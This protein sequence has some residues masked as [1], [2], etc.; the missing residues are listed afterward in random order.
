M[1]PTEVGALGATIRCIVTGRITQCGDAASGLRI[2]AWHDLQV[3]IPYGSEPCV[4]GPRSTR[5]VGEDVTDAVGGFSLTFDAPAEFEEACVFSSTVRIHVFDGA[6]RLWASAPRLVRTSVRIDHELVPGCTAASTGVRVINDSGIPVGGAQVFVNGELSGLTGATGHLVL[7]PALN[8]GDCLAAR[9]LVHENLVSRDEHD[10]D[11]NQN[12]NYRVY[13][14]SVRVRHDNDGDNIALEQHIVSN[15]SSV[16]VLRVR[17][18]NALV[19]LNLRVSIEWDASSTDS[20]RF[21]DRFS[22]MSELL[23]NATDGQFLV[24]RLAIADD[25]RFWDEADFRIYANQNQPSVATKDGMFGDTG[26]VRMNPNDANY[27]GTLLHELGHFGFGLGDEYEAADNWDPS[28]GPTRCT[29]RSTEPSGPYADGNEK[30]SCLM[31]GNRYRDQKKFCS[32]HPDA[33]HVDGTDQGPQDC[34]TDILNR[35][36]QTRWLLR[37]PRSRG[38]ILGRIPDSGVSLL[39]TSDPPSDINRPQSFIPLSGWKTI[40]RELR[41]NRAGLCEGLV[42]RIEQAGEPVIGA[43]IS[44]RTAAGRDLYLGATKSQY[45][46][47]YGVN[48]GP[49]ELPLRGVPVRDDI[50]VRVF[51][52]DVVMALI[53][54]ESCNS[55]LAIGIPGIVPSGTTPGAPPAFVRPPTVRSVWPDERSVV[56]SGDGR[57]RV[58]LPPGSPAEP[59]VVEVAQIF[60]ARQPQ[61]VGELVSGPYA[62]TVSSATSAEARALLHFRIPSS[63]VSSYEGLQAIRIEPDGVVRDV[64]SSIQEEP[65][66]VT[67]KVD[68][69]GTYA[70]VARTGASSRSAK[71]PV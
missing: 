23:Y 58:V 16:Q 29:L 5:N 65:F 41:V 17:R 39:G 33:P 47:A 51:P 43:Q 56:E 70:L 52:F 42:V 49:G 15:P 63:E 21:R 11:S 4:V 35:Y 53:R 54:V 48:T 9:L 69:L 1:G 26:Y 59:D 66:V 3:G 13:L 14:T 44:L 55:P 38:V 36:G 30:D 57:L 25:G 64:P 40:I 50:L 71:L 46:L 31:R 45:R 20:Q 7:T 18:S 10:D 12:W 62:I 60:P 22:D 32:S 34:W 68:Q 2:I 37:T 28:N 8:V 67:A 6:T 27:P 19:G 24:E 61:R